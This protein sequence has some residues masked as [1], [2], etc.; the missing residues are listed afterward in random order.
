[1]PAH[2]SPGEQAVAQISTDGGQNWIDVGAQTGNSN[3]YESTFNQKTVPLGQINSGA[4]VGATVRVRLL[5]RV[6]P[7]GSTFVFNFDTS[8]W[9]VDQIEVTNVTLVNGGGSNSAPAITS[10]GGGANAVVSVADNSTLVT[11]VTATDADAGSTLTYS[12]TGGADAAKFT[13]N[14]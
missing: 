8:G 12:I 4:Y 3:N 10:N 6:Q 13:I 5:Y 7:G 9:F 14:A 1:M 2:S 11:T